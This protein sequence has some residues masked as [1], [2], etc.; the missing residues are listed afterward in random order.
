M[1]KVGEAGQELGGDQRAIFAEAGQSERQQTIY[2]LAQNADENSLAP[3]FE[4]ASNTFL[5]LE[6]SSLNLYILRPPRRA[7][8][9]SRNATA[10]GA[11]RGRKEV[12]Q[13]FAG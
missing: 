5:L 4:R 10:T 3:V 1:S 9:P 2:K 8:R 12:V 11:A 6:H 7:S 13:P